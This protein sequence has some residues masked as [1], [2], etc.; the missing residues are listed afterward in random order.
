[1]S[2]RVEILSGL[3]LR[4]AAGGWDFADAERARID[5]HWQQLV[6]VNPALWNGVVLMCTEAQV[7]G[8]VLSA[9]FAE[10]DYASFI[11]WRDWGWPDRSVRNCFGV[12]VL[13]SSDGALLFGVMGSNTLNPGWRYPPSGS[14]ERRDV[15]ADGR[16]DIVGSMAAELT[17]ETGIGLSGTQPGPMVAIFEGQRLAVAQRFSATDEFAQLLDIFCRHTMAGSAHELSA[18]E[19]IRSAAQID[20]A[21]PPYAQEIVRIFL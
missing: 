6:S 9:R 8:G 7:A 21:M 16:V 20:A 13:R 17:E 3:D 11:A 1:M 4:M 19:A 18:V 2:I 10:T 12:P 15:L 14:L 5:A